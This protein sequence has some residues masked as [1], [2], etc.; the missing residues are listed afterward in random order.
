MWVIIVCVCFCALSC[1]FCFEITI[2]WQ[3]QQQ[4]QQ[5]LKQ[6]TQKPKTQT[7]NPKP[8]IQ[9]QE[10]RTNNQKT[11]WNY[12]QS[13]LPGTLYLSCLPCQQNAHFTLMTLPLRVPRWIYPKPEDWVFV[14]RD[15]AA[16]M[17][18]ASTACF[19]FLPDFCLRQIS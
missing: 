3:Q 19:S 9:N 7:Q 2:R 14:E 17:D 18:G 4:Q 10:P 12:S 5:H 6:R 11:K 15:P 8:K 1:R 13:P 16:T